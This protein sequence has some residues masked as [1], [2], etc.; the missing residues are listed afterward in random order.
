LQLTKGFHEKSAHS[1]AVLFISPHSHPACPLVAE[2]HPFQPNKRMNAHSKMPC[3]D[4]LVVW[5]C[6]IPQA[7]TQDTHPATAS[8]MSPET[9]G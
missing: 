2:A 7:Y 8:A 6:G 4:T 3:P 5:D 1:I 9:Q